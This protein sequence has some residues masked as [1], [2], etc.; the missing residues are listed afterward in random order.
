[1]TNLLSYL[2]ILSQV[3]LIRM[4][5]SL[6]VLLTI[7][8][9]LLFQDYPRAILYINIWFSHL[10]FILYKNIFNYRNI[11][12][13]SFFNNGNIFFMINVYS[14]NHQST[15]KYLKDTKVNI[16]N[17]L[18]IASDFNIRDSVWNSSF[19]FHSSH[20]GIL[21]EITDSFNICLSSSFN[22]Y[23]YNT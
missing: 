21:F 8:T 9:G 22:R 12:C 13:F 1:M 4:V 10:W 20:S 6:L 15:L 23:L 16:H 11:F 7:L 14:N 2:F 17:I 3:C 18:I 19:L 5:I